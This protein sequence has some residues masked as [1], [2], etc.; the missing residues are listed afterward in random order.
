MLS[1]LAL[2]IAESRSPKVDT[3]DVILDV[4][5][6]QHWAPT[7]SSDVTVSPIP[8]ARHDVYLSQPAVRDAALNRVEQWLASIGYSN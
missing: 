4:R 2:Q 5:Q 1:I 7:L 3:A 6:I 8:D